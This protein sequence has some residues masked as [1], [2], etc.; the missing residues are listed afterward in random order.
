MSKGKEMSLVEA[1]S[2][3]REKFPNWNFQILSFEKATSP[4]ILKCLDCQKE[5]HYKNIYNFLYKK[6]LAIVILPQVKIN[7]KE[8]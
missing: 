2:K 7:Q 6:I 4:I 1:Q 8:C 5:K 3:I